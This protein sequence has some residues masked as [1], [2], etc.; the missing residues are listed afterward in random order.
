MYYLK[1]F[2]GK[3]QN[4]Q[5]GPILILADFR[6]PPSNP[7]DVGKKW[8]QACEQTELEEG[9]GGGGRKFLVFHDPKISNQR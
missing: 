6:L 2:G 9:G 5:F 7:H 8:K 1:K 4:R 3:I